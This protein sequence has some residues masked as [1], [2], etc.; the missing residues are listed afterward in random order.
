MEKL[1]QGNTGTARDLAGEAVGVSGK[2][3]D[4]AEKIK[5]ANPTLFAEVKAGQKTLSQAMR[6][7]SQPEPDPEPE[8]EPDEEAPRVQSAD[9]EMPRARASVKNFEP[10]NAILNRIESAIQEIAELKLIQA[11][12]QSA[13]KTAEHTAKLLVEATLK[14]TS[15]AKP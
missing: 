1:P 10:F 13:R 14:A 9:E 6:E 15:N 2:L 8:P 12:A 4:H 7:I 3:V 11:H 5:A